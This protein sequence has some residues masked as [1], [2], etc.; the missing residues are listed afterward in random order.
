M[1]R[2]PV[3]RRK[4]SGCDIPQASLTQSLITFLRLYNLIISDFTFYSP[5]MP[6]LGSL[7]HPHG[8]HEDHVVD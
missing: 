1:C 7:S 8:L 4:P 5:N 3:A 6:N 2:T